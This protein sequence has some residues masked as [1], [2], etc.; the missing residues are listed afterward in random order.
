MYCEITDIIEDL[1]A[2]EVVRLVDDES[3]LELV[4]LTDVGDVATKRVLAQINAA[5]D[6]IDGY[7][8]SAYTLPFDIVPD[9]IRQ[10][11]KDISIYNLYKRRF[12]LE[13]P[14]TLV[15]IYKERI[16]ELT[17]IQKG[18]IKLDITI[19][20]ATSPSEFKVNKT[21]DNKIFNNLDQF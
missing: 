2:D 8:R 16:A 3:R 15:S 5:D 14:E 6:E 18:T 7:L 1:N 10:I 19:D 21:S 17:K 20:A 12:R 9:R 4:D 13:M 11:S